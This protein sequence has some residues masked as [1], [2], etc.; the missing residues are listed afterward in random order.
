MNE[1]P[2][3]S[4]S[5]KFKGAVEHVNS[6]ANGAPIGGRVH[7]IASI[8]PYAAKH[9][10]GEPERGVQHQPF[11]Y[12]DDDR[13]AANAAEGKAMNK[14]VTAK[15]SGDAKTVA[16]GAVIIE[17]PK[18]ESP[19]KES[20]AQYDSSDCNGSCPSRIQDQSITSAV[21]ATN[22]GGALHGLVNEVNVYS[23]NHNVDMPERHV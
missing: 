9:N 6:P 7:E 5:D 22:I 16:T 10:V 2:A 23:Y 20:L 11:L 4:I 14:G 1:N 3:D 12:G 13:K 19:K 21:N 17:K 15:D 18:K 8:E